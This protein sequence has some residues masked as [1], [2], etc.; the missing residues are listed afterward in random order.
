MEIQKIF[1]E[2]D[3]GEKLYSILL[4]E[5]ELAL[6]SEIQKN[7][8]RG[9]KEAIKQ[10]WKRTNGLRSLPNGITNIED[11]KAL[12]DLSNRLNKGGKKIVVTPE[13]QRALDNLGLTKV[14]P[15]FLNRVNKKYRNPELKERF[16]R[17]YNGGQLDF[18]KYT[19]MDVKTGR[20]VAEAHGNDLRK[21]LSKSKRYLKGDDSDLSKGII[22]FYRKKKGSVIDLQKPESSF[23]INKIR[24]GKVEE[25]I[26]YQQ[27]LN[28][29]AKF[30]KDRN[31]TRELKRY[32]D[33]PNGELIA[34]PKKRS[35]AALVTHEM[36]HNKSSRE[37]PTTPIKNRLKIDDAYGN[38]L[39]GLGTVAEENMASANALQMLKNQSNLKKH[40]SAL[41]SALNSYMIGSKSKI[42]PQK[43]GLINL[44]IRSK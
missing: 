28:Q 16:L 24:Q 10:I 42:L 31:N 33:N 6:F 23:S 2:I 1:S 20:H 43:Y 25:G 4:S 29:S 30:S 8:T 7:F 36:G 44:P 26:N 34:I 35:S 18:E 9:E 5:E 39:E 40:K 22:R 38:A 12:K 27:L 37:I 11:A 32:L 21:A 19:P 13:I 17:R 14:T 41:D 15:E 3:T